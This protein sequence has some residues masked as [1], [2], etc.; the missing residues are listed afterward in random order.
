MKP[1]DKRDPLAAAFR[2]AIAFLG[3]PEPEVYRRSSGVKG[4]LSINTS[5]V[6]VLCS[7]ESLA[8]ASEPEVR[9]MVGRA[10]AFSRPEN[11]L[12][13]THPLPKLRN[14]LDALVELAFPGERV[15]PV[16][17]AV[18]ELADR[19][20][21]VLPSHKHGRLQQLASRYRAQAEDL[22]IRTW[23]E[24]VEHTCNRTGFLLC[25]NLEAAVEASKPAGVVS[26]TGSNRSLIRELIFYTI[27]DAYF[28]LRGFLGAAID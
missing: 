22:S 10:M 5:P 9:F 3:L 17:P 27:S 11:L 15:H 13:T 25:S 23:Q 14:T 19:I 2:D 28:E 7:T 4:A 6:A 16:E 8:R 24:G 1:T 26:P 12:A 21:R 20:G 18:E